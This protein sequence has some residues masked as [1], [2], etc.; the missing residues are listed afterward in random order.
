MMGRENHKILMIDRLVSG[1]GKMEILHGVSLSVR[2]GE[3]VAL[4]G[5]NGAGKST[6]LKASAGLLRVTSGKVMFLDE[7]ITNCPPYQVVEKGL[8]FNPQGRVVFP[9]MTVQEH[10]DMGA[11]TI[12]D[13]QEK[14]GALERILKLFPWLMEKKKRKAS[15]MSGGEQQMLSLARA[16]MIQPRLLL[17]DEPSLGLSPKWVKTVFEKIVE[18]KESGIPCLIVEQKAAMVLEYSDYGYVLEMGNNRFEGRGKELLENPD[19]RRL[20]LGG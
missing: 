12:K 9:D 6:V 15:Q 17:L 20:Y 11:W 3:I 18:I 4:I 14:E 8:A 1:Y 5:P 19:V 2:E 10:L 16:M 13:R 7:E